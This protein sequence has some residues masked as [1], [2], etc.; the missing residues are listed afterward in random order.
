MNNIKLKHANVGQ[1][2]INNDETQRIKSLPCHPSSLYV[3]M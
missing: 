3:Y 1:N 2:Y